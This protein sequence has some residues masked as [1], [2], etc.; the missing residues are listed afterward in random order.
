MEEE[1]T[2]LTVEPTKVRLVTKQS[3]CYS[4]CYITEVAHLFSKNLSDHGIAAYKELYDGVG[5]SFHTVS[6]IGTR[7]NRHLGDPLGISPS[8]TLKDLPSSI[9]SVDTIQNTPLIWM[10][11]EATE[12]Q[13]LQEELKVTKKECERLTQELEE[14]SE[15]ATMNERLLFKCLEAFGQ[16]A[17]LVEQVQQECVDSMEFTAFTD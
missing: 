10:S 15:R 14:K 4:W 5:Q 17:S 16:V 13:H 8:L 7:N 12:C 1:V 11:N 2:G 3:D 9:F 6:F